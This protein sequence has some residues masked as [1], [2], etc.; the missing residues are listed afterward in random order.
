MNGN[1][2]R[3]GVM[4]CLFAGV[5][6]AGSASVAHADALLLSENVMVTAPGAPRVQS[7]GTVS[8]GT[9]TMSVTDLLWPQALQSLSFSINSNQGVLQKLTGVGSLS[10]LV[11]GPMT[12]FAGVY[13]Q[14][15]G[16]NGVGLYHVNV[17][18]V[19][20]AAPPVPLPA[21]GWLLLSGI[22]GLASSSI[23]VFR[24]HREMVRDAFL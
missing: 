18:F 3:N 24:M 22:A 11:T 17:T 19:A 10:Y 16:G 6:V 5:F 13:A 12:L 14:P 23:A 9:L 21:A 1:C 2:V 7:L 4:A 15:N 8:A 20:A